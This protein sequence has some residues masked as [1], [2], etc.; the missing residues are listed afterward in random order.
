MQNE[1]TDEIEPRLVCQDCGRTA[2]PGYTIDDRCVRLVRLRPRG[3][4][5]QCEGRLENEEEN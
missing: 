5:I 3:P 4:W 2:D 1:K